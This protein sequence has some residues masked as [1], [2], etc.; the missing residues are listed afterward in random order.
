MKKIIL[1]ICAVLVLILLG[2]KTVSE[3]IIIP[4]ESIRI[5]VI[6]NS[7]SIK[8]Q[9]LKKKVKKSIQV[10]LT[11][12]LKD[13][14]SINDVRAV[15]NEKLDGIKYSVKN[16]INI[17][18]NNNIKYDVNYGYNFFPQKTYKGVIYK[19][20]YYESIVIKL[21]EAQGDNWWCVLFPPLCLMDEDEDNTSEVEYKSFVKELIEKYF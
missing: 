3:D 5:R 6:A 11:N 9:N 18:S 13:A 10:E 19:E 21:G 12:M 1:F 4:N 2:G 20:G 16:T 8:D 17:N 14:K 15:L 7:N